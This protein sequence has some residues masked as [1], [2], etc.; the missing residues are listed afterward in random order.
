VTRTSVAEGA[1]ERNGGSRP[2]RPPA[3]AS[4]HNLRVRSAQP[5]QLVDAFAGL[6]VLV[7]GDA[8]LDSY[9][10]GE[11]SRISAE[12]PVP[13]V[14][15][16][17]REDVPGGAA[18]A[19]ANAA[20]LGAEAALV[21]AV[22]EDGEAEILRAVLAERGVAVD[23]VV[24]E[25]GRATQAKNRVV[26]GSQILVRFDLGSG[27][28][29]GSGTEEELVERLADA[30][31]S[32]DAVL[33]SD[34]GYGILTPRL[35]RGLAE[36]QAESPRILVVDSKELGAY[37]EVGAT[38]VKPNYGQALALVGLGAEAAPRADLVAAH[39]ERILDVTGAQ[40]AAVTLDSEGAVVLERGRP[41]YRTYAR[42]G[43]HASAQ[44]AGD[45]FAAALAL[46]LA[47]GAHTP[48]AAELASAA[49]GVVVGKPRTA[50]CTVGEL[51][52]LL[53]GGTKVVDEPDRLADVLAAHRD[54][55]RRIV[56]TNG[57]FDILHRGHITYLSR[58]KTLGDV[59]VVGL[60]SDASVGRLK[61]PGRPV[62]AL[63]DRA[64]V[65]AAL[66]CVDLVVPFAEDTPVELLRAVRPD[67]FVKGG[68]YTR[69]M[70]PEAPVVEALGGTVH[71]L[72]YVEDRSTTGII[73]RIREAESAGT[74]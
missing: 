20:A 4:R 18:N 37:R 71:L 54:R 10:E 27:E 60:N 11:S 65:L 72:P 30:W 63:D 29:L 3:S 43:S 57:C 33:V 68:D 40:V 22:G 1:A 26:A 52:E 48:A 6:R 69:E 36:L 12:A 8:M 5:A 50:V 19:A 66:S 9:L 13:V 23:H 17:A 44:G 67:V 38:A 70:L 55:G 34:Y 47:A 41:A 7:V 51:R 73:E 24:G 31:S 35:V 25:P 58:A 56:F 2:A 64:H 62:N 14:S 53:A 74:G 61:G 39:G 42:R 59:L 15:V 32:A 46:A 21:S 45:T 49:A 28:A 16:G